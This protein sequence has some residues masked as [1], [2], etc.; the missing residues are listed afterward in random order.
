VSTLASLIG[1]GAGVIAIAVAMVVSTI[2]S[3]FPG[4]LRSWI[5]RVVV[6]LMYAGG[7]AIAVTSLGNWGRW[8]ITRSADLFGGLG[9]AIPQTALVITSIVL[10]V[11]VVV[12]LIWEPN[13]GTGMVAAVLPLFL[14]LVTGGA[15][16][17]IYLASVVPGQALASALSHAI[18][19]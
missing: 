2:T 10:M 9:A 18:G 14:G 19:G 6:V 3:R 12:S 15:I 13:A 17:Q 16:H 8:L 7:S 11:A 1:S 4:F 5:E